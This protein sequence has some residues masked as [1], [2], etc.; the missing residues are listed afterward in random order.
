MAQMVTFSELFCQQI[1]KKFKNPISD[2]AG[3]IAN[4]SD[5]LVFS[6]YRLREKYRKSRKQ[7]KFHNG[8]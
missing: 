7:K 6:K 5:Y 4:P 8:N 1:V 2:A 3:A